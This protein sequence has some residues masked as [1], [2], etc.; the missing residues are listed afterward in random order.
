MVRQPEVSD[1]HDLHVWTIAGGMTALSAHVQVA[2]RPLSECDPLLTRLN[3]LL[4]EKYHI[5]HS[6]LQ[7]ECAGCEP[8]HLYCT[9]GSQGESEHH[10]VHG[11]ERT[12]DGFDVTQDAAGSAHLP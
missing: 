9:G 5:G 1:V 4:Q 3:T 7:L 11:H 12:P 6:T 8:N 2:D 10:H